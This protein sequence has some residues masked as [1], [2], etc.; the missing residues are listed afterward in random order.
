MTH[1]PAKCDVTF[2]PGGRRATVAKGTTVLEAARAAGVEINSACGGDGLCGK[3][4]VIV[5]SGSVSA[6]ATALLS[7][8]EMQQH[9]VL[10][11]EAAADGDT[12]I[13]VPAEA[14]VENGSILVD[15]FGSPASRFPMEPLVRKAFLR[16]PPPSVQSSLAD[17]ER[18]CAGIRR[19]TGL[20]HVHTGY[21]VLSSLHVVLREA[22][23]QVTA[24]VADKGRTSELI[25]LER[26]DTTSRDFAL[27]VDVGTTTVAATLMNLR[28]G[29]TA[30]TEAMYNSQMAFGDD[31]IR[32][33]IHAEENNAFDQMQRL[34]VSN[35]NDLA[36]KLADEAG[37]G[38]DDINAVVCCGNTVMIHFLLRLPPGSI[39][40]EP[41]IPTANSI[42]PLRAAEIGI[43]INAD[44][45]LYCLPGVAAYVGSDITAGTVAIGLQDSPATCLFIDVGTN[46]EV[47]LGNREWMVCC[48]AS[49]GPAFEGGGVACGMRAAAGAIDR[50]RIS[51]DSGV[52]FKTIGGEPPRGIC[53]TGLIDALAQMYDT[54]IID[55]A[56]RLQPHRSNL[57]R[58]GDAGPEFV[59]VAAEHAPTRRD[60][61]LTQGD[62]D[63]LVRSKAA[64]Y[65]AVSVLLNSMNMT[66]DGVDR[67]FL[68]GG[69]GTCLDPRSAI[70]LGMLPDIPHEKIIFVG[71]TALRGAKLALLSQQA[72]EAI[73]D[74]AR[75]M[76][77]FDLMTDPT[78]MEAFQSAC[79]I[80]HTNL[81]RFPSVAGRVSV[82]QM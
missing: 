4:K 19:A 78:Y 74:V 76:T 26:G 35:I 70:T 42:P 41:Y 10:A 8:D 68:A 17:Y 75:R 37:I 56:G 24:T 14:R 2:Q 15:A 48:S 43:R 33:I 63:N 18:V 12:V 65:A 27:A 80:P 11:C 46:G 21:T 45:L 77:Y 54:G 16:L 61:V 64:I 38:L 50:V 36:A 51:R 55:R 67:V 31:Y 53:G 5:R 72:F 62:I 22:D 44:G 69:F 29:E 52:S 71:N 81:E 39:R 60:I 20:A 73:E 34:I 7:P 57:I 49:A 59:L 30:G 13:E 58:Q 1:E 23:W 40:R 66:F 82:V 6:P 28:T 25:R 32:R 9:Y 3:C 47:V 79:F